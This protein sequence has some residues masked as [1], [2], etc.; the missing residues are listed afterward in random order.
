MRLS[1]ILTKANL[2]GGKNLSKHCE[3]I[4]KVH[5]GNVQSSNGCCHAKNLYQP[6]SLVSGI[7]AT[8][9]HA[10]ILLNLQHEFTCRKQLK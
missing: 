10:R 7:N 9:D 4:K 2:K 6:D 3:S 1:R 8:K 5:R